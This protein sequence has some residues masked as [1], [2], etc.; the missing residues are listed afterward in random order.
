[1]SRSA[2]YPQ[3]GRPQIGRPQIG[4]PQIARHQI[5]RPQIGRSLFLKG[6][7]SLCVGLSLARPG[8]ALSALGRE[9]VDGLVAALHLNEG[10][11]SGAHRPYPYCHL[12]ITITITI[13]VIIA[14]EFIGF[15]LHMFQVP[16]PKNLFSIHMVLSP[17]AQHRFC[18]SYGV[19]LS[20]G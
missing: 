3:I 11:S 9:G 18:N 6:L 13:T 8:L 14:C 20:I 19:A 5:R 2:P 15:F 16:G 4:R 17:W 1:M 12:P 7:G 10:P